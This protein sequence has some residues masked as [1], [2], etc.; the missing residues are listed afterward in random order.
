MNASLKKGDLWSEEFKRKLRPS[1]QR[2]G[3][4]EELE[5]LLTLFRGAR[6]DLNLVR[7][8]HNILKLG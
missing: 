7:T 2:F 3:T 4:K 8:Y 1:Q 5:L 6:I